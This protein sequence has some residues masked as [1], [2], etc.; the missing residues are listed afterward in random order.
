[1]PPVDS[2]F[3]PAGPAHVRWAGPQ[4]VILALGCNQGPRLHTFDRACRVLK[5]EGIRVV[6]RSRLYETKPLP[7]SEGPA[8]LNACVQV[9]T[10][11]DPMGLL[12]RCQGIEREFGRVRTHRWSRRPLDIDLILYGWNRIDLEDLKIPHPAWRER[13]FILEGLR[14]LG[15][16][17]LPLHLNPEGGAFPSWLPMAE[18]CILAAYPWPSAK[19]PPGG[20]PVS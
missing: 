11:L 17:R 4:P 7:G 14:D 12:A 6:K 2:R 8:Y 1:M 20:P 15:L 3:D 16:N 5:R 13:D 19:A 18:N 10:R 9:Q